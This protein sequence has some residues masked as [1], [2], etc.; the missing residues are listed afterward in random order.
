METC[1]SSADPRFGS[2]ERC[3]SDIEFRRNDWIDP[4]KR[5]EKKEGGGSHARL[6]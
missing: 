3:Q 1:I 5:V 2:W 4:L 6:G